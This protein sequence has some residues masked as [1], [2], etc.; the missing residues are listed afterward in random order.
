MRWR[1]TRSATD[2]LF[3]TGS[4]TAA[5]FLSAELGVELTGG[6]RLAAQGTARRSGAA[7]RRPG[8]SACRCTPCCAPHETLTLLPRI[9][10]RLLPA[11]RSR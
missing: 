8:S 5:P 9:G 10:G 7:S 11:R 4:F 1:C 3:V 6:G 2:G